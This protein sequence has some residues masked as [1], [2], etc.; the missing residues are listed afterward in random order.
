M[1]NH[2][3]VIQYYAI[4]Q[5]YIILQLILQWL[6]VIHVTV[7]QDYAICVSQS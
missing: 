4:C 7:I 1:V 5:S 2:V 3:T 6:M